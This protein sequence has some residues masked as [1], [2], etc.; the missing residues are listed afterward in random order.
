MKLENKL[1]KYYNKSLSKYN[2]LDLDN[3]E[4]FMPYFI[5]YLRLRRDTL[6]LNEP[7]YNPETNLKIASICFAIV[8]YEQSITCIYKYYNL[9]KSVPIIKDTTKAPEQV[10]QEYQAERLQHWNTFCDLIRVNM[11]NWLA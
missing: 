2:K 9:V 4:F 6:I 11:E 8:E 1:R 5:T 10:A 3:P 7:D